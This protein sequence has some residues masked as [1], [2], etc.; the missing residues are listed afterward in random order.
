MWVDNFCKILPRLLPANALEL[1]KS[2]LWTV[3]G[4]FQ[5]TDPRTNLT[6]VPD[7]PALPR[8]LVSSGFISRIRELYLKMESQPLLR[9]DNS[10]SRLMSRIPLGMEETAALRPDPNPAFYPFDLRGFNIGSNF[11]LVSW[12][13]DL[14]IEEVKNPTNMYKLMLCDINIFTRSLRVTF[15]LTHLF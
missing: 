3:F 14:R 2:C 4:L 6:I 5:L 9:Y 8:L 7:V 13:E 1:F 15:F 12:L 10:L 11:G